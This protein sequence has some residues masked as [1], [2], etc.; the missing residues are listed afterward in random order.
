MFKKLVNLIIENSLKKDLKNLFNIQ[1]IVLIYIFAS[2]YSDNLNLSI[3]YPLILLIN[4]E[5][6][7]KKELIAPTKLESAIKWVDNNK[8]ILIIGF[9]VV[10]CVI[11]YCISDIP[12][13]SPTDSIQSIGQ[14]VWNIK[15]SYCIGDILYQ[16]EVVDNLL[17][18]IPEGLTRANLEIHPLEEGDYCIITYKNI[19]K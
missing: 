11:G 19:Q 14:N 6:S 12:P 17:D 13:V 7:D 8:I 5:I 2:I 9:I 18:N 15:E 1:K 3:I 4:D 16:G 10:I